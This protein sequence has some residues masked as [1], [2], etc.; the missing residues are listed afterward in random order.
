MK[1]NRLVCCFI[2]ETEIMDLCGNKLQNVTSLAHLA[3]FHAVTKPPIQSCDCIVQGGAHQLKAAYVSLPG[4]TINCSITS[5]KVHWSEGNAGNKTWKISNGSSLPNEC[6]MNKSDITWIKYKG[7]C[8]A[9]TQTIWLKVQP[10]RLI[11]FLYM[12]KGFILPK[13]FFSRYC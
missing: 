13:R 11:Y 3:Y 12:F 2:T 4:A 10:G 7:N 9:I 5:L 1:Y 6:L 8:S